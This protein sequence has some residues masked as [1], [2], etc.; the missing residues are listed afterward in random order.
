MDIQNTKQS[1][2]QREVMRISY[3]MVTFIVRILMIGSLYHILVIYR[4]PNYLD[5]ISVS[6]TRRIPTVDS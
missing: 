4:E 5:G 6:I 1:M 3:E 2:G